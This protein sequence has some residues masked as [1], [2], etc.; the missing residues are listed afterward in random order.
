[1]TTLTSARHGTSSLHLPVDR[2]RRLVSA[3]VV[4]LGLVLIG[5]TFANNLFKVGPS[6]ESLMTDFRPHLTSSAIASSRT[7]LATLGA[8]GTEL[9]TKMVP[10]MAQQLG[11]TPDQFTAYIATTYPKVGAGMQS[12]PQIVSTFDGLVTTLD[13]QR[14]LFRSADAIP[15]KDLPAT[16]VPWSLAGAGVLMLAVGGVMWFRPRLGA[17]LAVGL[18]VLLVAV[19]LILSLPGKAGDADD[20]NANLKPI[21]TAALVSQSQTALTT[22]SG[23][24]TELQ[25]TMLPALAAQLK[26]TPAQLQQFMAGSFPATSAALA[27]LPTAMPRF[28]SMVAAFD[29]NLGNYNTLKPVSFAPIIWTL[30]GLGLL[31]ALAGGAVLAL[32][33]QRVVQI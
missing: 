23:M 31:T 17:G 20:L 33:R 8:A 32:P 1:M 4:V 2:P 10:A 14:P 13:Q 28:Q 5:L 3:L 22:V 15:T 27:S 7:D 29:D 24:A 12:L 6:F 25:T 19:P 21:Y 18:G 11:M 9:Q 16:T 30:M 26:M